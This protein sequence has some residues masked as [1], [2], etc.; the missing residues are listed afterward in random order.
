MGLRTSLR[1][2]VPCVKRKWFIFIQSTTVNY[3]KKQ[4][5]CCRF[6]N[7]SIIS[8]I[9]EQNIYQDERLL[10]TYFLTIPV[11]R[12]DDEE[13]TAEDLSFVTVEKFLAKNL[14]G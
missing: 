12:V 5:R 14:K 1:G 9:V 10:E 4:N 6:F 3:V 7:R 13:L 8:T 11:I 2:K